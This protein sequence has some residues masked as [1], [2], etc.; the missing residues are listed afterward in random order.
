[1]DLDKIKK[2][3]D[4]K[5][6]K[7]KEKDVLKEKHKDLS[8]KLFD[9]VDKR[10]L[11]EVSRLKSSADQTFRRFFGDEDFNV[12]VS[13]DRLIATY[14]DHTIKFWWN[15]LKF[16]VDNKG[17]IVE[18]V[19]TESDSSEFKYRPFIV[20]ASGIEFEIEKLKF[21]IEKFTKKLEHLEANKTIY[22]YEVYDKQY[23]TFDTVLRV[24]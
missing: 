23:L 10:H 3:E 18:G 5:S 16:Y 22:C 15:D 7:I 9:E 2:I 24:I 21:E 8:N 17:E 19:I 4:A 11:N 14:G 20:S 12:E 13:D 1:M 6:S